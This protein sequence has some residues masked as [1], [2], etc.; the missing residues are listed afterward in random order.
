MLTR[1]GRFLKVPADNQAYPD[2]TLRIRL[3]S[4]EVEFVGNKPGIAEEFSQA[5]RY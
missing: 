2:G 5:C 1:C 4:A 3:S